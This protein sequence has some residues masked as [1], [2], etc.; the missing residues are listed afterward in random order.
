MDFVILSNRVLDS[1]FRYGHMHQIL[2]NLMIFKALFW[3]SYSDYDGSS[4]KRKFNNDQRLVTVLVY[5]STDPNIFIFTKIRWKLTRWFFENVLK[6]TIFGS[7]YFRWNN[8]C[9]CIGVSDF[10]VGWAPAE[11]NWRCQNRI[12]RNWK[13][14]SRR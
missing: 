4:H 7:V 12:G 10:C 11:H 5:H 3:I 9:W 8:R 13:R 1:L 6:M 14:Y 2:P